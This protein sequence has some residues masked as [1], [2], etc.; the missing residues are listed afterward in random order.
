MPSVRE[1]LNKS[2]WIGWTLAFVLLAASAYLYFTRGSDVNAYNP[3]RMREFVT[4]KYAD[5]GETEKMPRGKFERALRE[6]NKGQL[7]GSKGLVNPKTG[8]PSGFLF[9]KDDWDTT[10]ARI[11]EERKRLQGDAEKA[12]TKSTPLPMKGAAPSP[13]MPSELKK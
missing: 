3:E 2:P 6:A 9:D 11:N 12:A 5:T 4:V 1:T 13:E 10:I 8:Q 7:D